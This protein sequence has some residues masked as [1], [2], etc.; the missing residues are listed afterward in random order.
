LGIGKLKGI[1]HMTAY[2]LNGYQ[3]VIVVKH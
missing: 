2:G 1:L 3:T